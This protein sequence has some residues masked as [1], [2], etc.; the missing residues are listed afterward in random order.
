MAQLGT[1][2]HLPGVA[3]FF[4]GQV[5]YGVGAP[6]MGTVTAYA[7]NAL[8]VSGLGSLAL[9]IVL[10]MFPRCGTLA[11]LCAVSALFGLAGTAQLTPASALLEQAVAGAV[12]RSPVLL[13]ALFNCAYVLGMC[14][15]PGLLA[16]L[17][18]T[19]GFS[20]ATVWLAGVAGT[21]AVL[22][23]VGLLLCGVPVH[24]P[25]G[26]RLKPM[27]RSAGGAETLARPETTPFLD[28]AAAEPVPEAAVNGRAPLGARPKCVRA[29]P[30]AASAQ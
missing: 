7:D 4:L 12:E 3:P 2:A 9:S 28:G 14:V 1:R 16:E 22:N 8:I 17:T 18:D 19:L 25:C 15:G 11:H 10:P 21:L 23:A 29:E 13:Y 30:P 6:L 26:P 24:L 20:T 27:Q 5:C